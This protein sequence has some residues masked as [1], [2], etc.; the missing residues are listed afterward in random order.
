MSKSL[1]KSEISEYVEKNIKLLSP[2]Y[3]NALCVKYSQLKD[4]KIKH[5]VVYRYSNGSALEK[6]N[7]YYEWMS[8]LI[9]YSIKSKME[10]RSKVLSDL[11]S[12]MDYLR[13]KISEATD[14]ETKVQRMTELDKRR[15]SYLRVWKMLK[16]IDDD[17]DYHH[18]HRNAYNHGRY[19]KNV[20]GGV[21]FH[22]KDD[23]GLECV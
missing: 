17:A 7:S 5:S 19:Y 23:I 22:F 3:I 6:D 16:S 15:E 18:R 11:R 13:K 9:D 8:V 4:A 10:E 14:D 1:S 20:G 12:R 21:F 2:V